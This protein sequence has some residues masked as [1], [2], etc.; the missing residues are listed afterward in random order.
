MRVLIRNSLANRLR[1][2]QRA[3]FFGA[4]RLAQLGRRLLGQ[5]ELSGAAPFAREAL[6]TASWRLP[7]DRRTPS[8]KSLLGERLLGETSCRELSRS[9]SAPTAWRG[10]TKPPAGRTWPKRGAGNRNPQNDGPFNAAAP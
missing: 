5:D 1:L 9:S 4:A 7:D 6:L 2:G 3:G 8:V 10:F